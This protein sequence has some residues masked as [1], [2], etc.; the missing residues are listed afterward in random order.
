M[1]EA[2]GE[3]QLV[4]TEAVRAVMLGLVPW[5]RAGLPVLLVGPE[6][7]GKAQLL[8]HCFKQLLV[9]LAIDL[10]TQKLRVP[11]LSR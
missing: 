5:L 1:H 6:G 3:C 11:V 8:Q 4:V 10:V 7:C 9:R 2:E